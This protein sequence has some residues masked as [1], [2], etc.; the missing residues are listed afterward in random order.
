MLRARQE[1]EHTTVLTAP[2]ERPSCS[3]LST[4]GIEQQTT[5]PLLPNGRTASQHKI[6]PSPCSNRETVSVV[7]STERLVSLGEE[8]QCQ[9]GPGLSRQCS[10][11][12]GLKCNLFQ[13]CSSL[14]LGRSHNELQFQ[15]EPCYDQSLPRSGITM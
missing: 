10:F 8:E 3:A 2:A 11:A 5:P 4:A 6:P 15:L 13:H 9:S 12:H 7:R 14:F 1:M